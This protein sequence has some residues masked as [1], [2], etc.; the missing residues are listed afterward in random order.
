MCFPA[1]HPNDQV[2]TPLKDHRIIGDDFS[3]AVPWRKWR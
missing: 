3:G 1:R 2:A